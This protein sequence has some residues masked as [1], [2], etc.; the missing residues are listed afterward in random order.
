MREKKRV[1]SKQPPWEPASETEAASF[2]RWL[3]QQ[4]EVREIS[5]REISETS[6]ISLRYLEAF[7]E[8]RFDLLPAQVFANGFLRQYARYVGLDPDDVVN[9]F[10]V[11]RR[12]GEGAEDEAPSAGKPR[13]EV[14]RRNPPRT[15]PLLALI[16]LVALAL[17][18][19]V[20]FVPVYLDS[21]AA[22]RKPATTVAPPPPP[23]PS[24]DLPE[25]SAEVEAPGATASSP[26]GAP[27]HVTLEFLAEC[28]Y[29]AIVDGKSRTEEIRI[30]GE[31][32][33]LEAQT[34][35]DLKFGNAG[36]VSM[37]V[38]GKPYPLGASPGEVKAVRLDLAA[39]G[40]TE[41][42][43]ETGPPPAAPRPETAPV[44]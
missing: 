9:R 36:G 4:R 3:R 5:L 21:R 39:L 7:E 6:K 29:E 22:A 34:R 17:L 35:L 24:P 14:V 43:S 1:N 11:A 42:P 41:A 16:G 8:D 19:L 18:A 12:G 33:E 37:S 32:V 10:L 31:T 20:F 23:V 27:I 26:S 28:W 30:Q 2:G 44:P 25:P 40:I 38:N 13:Q 15:W